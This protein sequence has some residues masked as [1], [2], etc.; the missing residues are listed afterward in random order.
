VSPDEWAASRDAMAAIAPIFDQL[1]R[2]INGHGPVDMM[3][4]YCV[5]LGAIQEVDMDKASLER[6]VAVLMADRT[7]HAIS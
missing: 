2:V 7:H 1:E 5:A 4:A 3:T 6:F